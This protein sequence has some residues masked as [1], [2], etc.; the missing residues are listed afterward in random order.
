MK[1]WL[2][3]GM[4]VA[5]LAAGLAFL[6]PLSSVAQQ[7]QYR[8]PRTA[9]GKPDLNGVWQAMNNATL[10]HAGSRGAAGP[11]G[12]ARRSVQRAGGLRRRRGQRDPVPARGARQEEG[13]RS[14]T[15]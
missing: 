7:A 5:V 12:R 3:G 9:D 13:E 10:G 4:M 11:G 14:R 2:I 1:K 15:G 8:A 6:W